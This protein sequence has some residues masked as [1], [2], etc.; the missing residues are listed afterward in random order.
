VSS[1]TSSTGTGG[2]ER[3][4]RLRLLAPAPSGSEPPVLELRGEFDLDTVPEIDR[5]LRRTLGPLYH[6]QHLVIDLERT[7]FVDSSLIAFLVRL[8]GDQRA[9][10]KELVLAR[11]HGQ[12]RRVVALVGL[13]NIVPV[14]DSVDEAVGALVSGSL[15][16]IPPAFR[17][18]GS[19]A[20]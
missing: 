20:S 5:F 4:G 6:Q 16:V 1:K 10:R 11:P 3:A 9:E 15:P 19:D 14:F 18:A 7:T 8:A 17:A 2:G 12:V 13:H